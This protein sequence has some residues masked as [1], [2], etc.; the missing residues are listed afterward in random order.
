MKIVAMKSKIRKADDKL[1]PLFAV[2]DDH[3]HTI[4]QVIDYD[5]A[6][7]VVELLSDDQH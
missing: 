6:T 5:R 7:S 4:I 1:H 3:G 2:V